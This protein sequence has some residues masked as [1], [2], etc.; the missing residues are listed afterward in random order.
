LW[1]VLL[2]PAPAG[3]AVAV[4][5]QEVAMQVLSEGSFAPP[6]SHAP[7]LDAT[8]W[9][10]VALPHAIARTLLPAGD[11]PVDTAWFRISVPPQ[12]ADVRPGELM[13]YVP[14]WQTVGR[15]AVYADGRLVW[16]SLGGPVW[17]G[18]N[19]P[20][21][22]ALEPAA[23]GTHAGEVLL[24]VD[25]RRS[26]GAVLSTAW[27]GDAAGLGARRAAREWVQS[28]LV[29]ASSTIYLAV[30]LFALLVWVARREAAYG[31][32]FLSAA[33][34]FVRSMHFYL[35]TEPL[36][37]SEA[38]FGWWTVHSLPA[39][40]VTNN[41][42][43]LRLAGRRLPWLEV[44]LIGLVAAAAVSGLPWL[45]P[46]ADT[47]ALSPLLYAAAA[48]GFVVFCAFTLHAVWRSGSREGLIVS[49]FNALSIPAT[50]HDWLLQNYRISPES[51]YLLPL[52]SVGLFAGFLYVVVRRYL[53]ALQRSERAQEHLA[54]QLDARERELRRTYERLRRAEHEHIVTHE[55]QRLM[56][57][58]HDGLGSSLISALKAVEHGHAHDVAE[59]LRQCLDDLKLAID[60]L[61]PLQADLLVLLGTLRYRLGTRLEQ[62]GVQLEWRVEE[63]PPLDWLDP[64]S[65]LQILRIL[66]EVLAN[67]VRHGQARHVVVATRAE[68]I[69]VVVSVRDDGVGFDTDVPHVGRGLANVRQRAR[70]LDAAAR[71]H[72]GAAGTLF[73]L[74]LPLQR[75]LPAQATSLAT[76]RA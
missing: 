30:G 61:E 58:M 64:R 51:V 59:V 13:L 57:D 60:S 7:A 71:W 52:A 27:V 48:A 70:S 23:G 21:W 12:A 11:D 6:P 40:A 14:R 41:V 67:A 69:S 2:A 66:Q 47:V 24:R 20:L 72:S 22:V 36:P 3:A 10:P 65:A 73:E 75:P 25:Y 76:A 39:L 43:A 32:F 19:H 68:A 53:A 26:A 38:W 8:R 55:R 33:L 56:Q 62:A 28:G 9:S 1:A 50:A 54:Q 63:I 15:I 42:F 34:F 37:V 35:G 74:V 29:E 46:V 31:L 44:P 45:R 49:V 4:Q 17:N 5:L 18:F 16:R